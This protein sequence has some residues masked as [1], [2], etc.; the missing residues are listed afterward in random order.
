MWIDSE[1]EDAAL[2]DDIDAL[3]SNVYGD[4]AAPITAVAS[5]IIDAAI[6]QATAAANARAADLV[7]I[8]QQAVCLGVKFDL[9][10]AIT[11]GADPVAERRRVLKTAADYADAASCVSAA[12][13]MTPG[14][15]RPKAQIIK[16]AEAARRRD[17]AKSIDRGW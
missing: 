12:T 16:L 6:A 1:E 5:D 8:G 10:S 11:E 3:K 15:G 17:E 9:I 14:D 13:T 7:E 2:D 4:G